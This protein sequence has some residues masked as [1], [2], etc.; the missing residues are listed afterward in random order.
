[1]GTFSDSATAF[2]EKGSD[3][4][5]YSD[6][7]W[8]F[9]VAEIV[10]GDDPDLRTSGSL[11]LED[12]RARAAIDAKRY[13]EAAQLLEPLAE[14]G[15]AWART[16]LGWMYMNGHLGP[17]DITRA[18]DAFEKAAASGY[19]DGKYFLGLALLKKGDRGRAEIV[20]REGAAENH[21][22]CLS[23]LMFIGEQDAWRA[24][25]AKHYREAARLLEPLAARGSVYALDNLGWMYKHGHLGTPDIAKA[26]S[27]WEESARNGSRYATVRI[28]RAVLGKDPVRARA[29]FL[30]GAAQG[31]KPSMYWAGRML[32]RGQGGEVDRNAGVAL[33]TRAAEN[34]HIY[35]R[36]DLLRLELRDE[37]TVLGRLRVRTKILLFALAFLLRACREPDLRYSD[38]FQ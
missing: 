6:I 14:G 5:G 9:G 37:P 17:R 23:E 26:I 34:G 10:A 31:H 16:T 18:I 29:L 11:L 25:E 19:P 28:A 8:R 33:L 35:A 4:K 1:M 27:L 38:D 15:S 2:P 13:D 20:L 32:L 22:G 21:A 12:D 24:I 36:G 7:A 30:E 3:V